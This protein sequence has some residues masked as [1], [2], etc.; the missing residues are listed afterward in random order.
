MNIRRSVKQKWRKYETVTPTP[1]PTLTPTQTL[2]GSAH[3]HKKTTKNNMTP[4]FTSDG[5][6]GSE[7]GLGGGGGGGG[8][9]HFKS[10]CS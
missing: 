3:T 4:P 8:G 7:A 2:M 9:G 5:V 10:G 1:T 6:G